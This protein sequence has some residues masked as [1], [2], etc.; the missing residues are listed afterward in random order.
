ML[1]YFNLAFLDTSIGTGFFPVRG[2]T[3]YQ[4]LYCHTPI[5]NYTGT[6]IIFQENFNFENEILNR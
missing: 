6:V 4:Y 5:S 2:P 1:T 3:V